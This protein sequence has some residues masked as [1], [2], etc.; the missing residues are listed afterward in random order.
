MG[1]LIS[2]TFMECKH[3]YRY[4]K[5]RLKISYY[6]PKTLIIETNFKYFQPLCLTFFCIFLL[7]PILIIKS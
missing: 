5:A 3:L 1:N 7:T 2:S 4:E 6:G